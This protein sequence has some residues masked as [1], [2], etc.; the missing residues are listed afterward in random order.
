MTIDNSRGGQV[1]VTSDQWGP[2]EGELLHTSYGRCTLFHVMTEKV[3]GQV[4]G[5]VFQFPLRFDSGVMR[6]RFHP[7]DGQLYLCGLGGGWQTS[8]AREGA[9]QRVR[10]T[11]KPLRQPVGL[12]VKREGVEITFAEALDPEWAADDGNYAIE[13]WNYRWTASYGSKDYAVSAPERQGRDEVEILAAE[14]SVV[15]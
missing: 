4:Q 15:E 8:G 2:L 11:G 7:R 12:R 14:L 5:G 13:Q 3:E 10:Y 6:G 9:L 1:W